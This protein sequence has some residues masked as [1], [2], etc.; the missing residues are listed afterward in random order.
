MKGN[1]LVIV[2]SDDFGLNRNVNKAIVESF[3]QGLIS[4]TT[5]MPTMPGFDEAVELAHSLKLTNKI[6]LHLNLTEGT[7]LTNELKNCTRFCNSEGQYIYD[8]KKPMFSLSQQEKQAL[9]KEITAQ[10]QRVKDA[11]LM[12]THL[13]SHHHVHTELGIANVYMATAKQFGIRKVRLTRNIGSPAGKV[14][15]LYKQLFNNYLKFY[16]GMNSTNFFCSADD[17][18]TLNTHL[19]PSNQSCE[20]MVHAVLDANGAIT[21]DDGI[22]LKEKISRLSNHYRL[23]SFADL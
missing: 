12:P 18:D 7:P 5:I 20:I 16:H 3:E 8:R 9:S 15:Q 6:G 11:G 17:I 1:C 19:I 23:G 21:D 14:K 4:S 10:L 13:D 2:N 22:S